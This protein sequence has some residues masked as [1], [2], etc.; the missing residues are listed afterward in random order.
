MAKGDVRPDVG[1]KTNPIPNGDRTIPR[2]IPFSIL[3][4]I[5]TCITAGKSGDINA[6]LSLKLPFFTSQVSAGFPSP[7]DD[8]LE[9]PLDLNQ[10][11][12]RHPAATFFVR[13]S[14]DSM[15]KAGI[16][17]NDILIVDRSLEAK[18]GSIVIAVIN[19]ELTVKRLYIKGKNMILKPENPH[20]PDFVLTQDLAFQIWGVVT[21]VIHEFKSHS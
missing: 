18:N 2:S 17:N 5:E 6:S 9:N 21:S 3:T 4:A 13:S 16:H 11:L 1:Q 14:G 15:I 10:Y 20:D 19:G 7:A 12:I 8:Y